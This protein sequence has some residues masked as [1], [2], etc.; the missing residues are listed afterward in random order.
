[1]RDSKRSA[2]L[3]GE[4]S[5]SCSRGQGFAAAR[6][7]RAERIP[8]RSPSPRW[9]RIVNT[10]DKSASYDDADHR[11]DAFFKAS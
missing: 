7:A 8:T 5:P 6:K 4:A 11:D 9:T 2:E 10:M 3:R 1:M